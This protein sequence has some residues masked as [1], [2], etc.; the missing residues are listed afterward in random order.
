MPLANRTLGGSPWE[1]PIGGV[2]AGLGAVHQ[3]YTGYGDMQDFG[4]SVRPAPPLPNPPAC[5]G[6]PCLPRPT[7]DHLRYQAMDSGDYMQR[8]PGWAH[9][10]YPRM[11]YITRCMRAGNGTGEGLVSLSMPSSANARPAASLAVMAAATIGISSSS[12]L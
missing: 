1:T 10:S 7:P 3:W 9:A 6:L 4:G 12:L 8:G 5:P 2:V 11:D